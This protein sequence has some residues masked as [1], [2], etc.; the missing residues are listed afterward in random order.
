V[1]LNLNVSQSLKLTSVAVYFASGTNLTLKG[2]GS[3]FYG[4]ESAVYQKSGGWTGTVYW[5]GTVNGA[6]I[7]T[8]P[9]KVDI[10]ELQILPTG[11]W[12]RATV[13]WA[14]FGGLFIVGVVVFA[15]TVIVYHKP[16]RRHKAETYSTPGS[17]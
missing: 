9:L 15:A 6:K 12:S 17:R 16:G 14:W 13:A 3:S 7:S 2:L 4:N 8:R 5:E 1:S 11:A 10:P